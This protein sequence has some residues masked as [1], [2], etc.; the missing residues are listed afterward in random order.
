[1]KIIEKDIESV[2]SSFDPDILS[3][4]T[5]FIT[6]GT[7]LIGKTL[8]PVLTGL[9]AKVLLLVRSEEK[10]K[11]LF[12]ET[13]AYYVGTVETI[14]A[15]DRDVDYVIHMASPT[16]SQFFVNHPV[17]T[18]TTAIQGTKNILELARQK[19]VSGLVYLSSME[20]YGYP[21]K[22]HMITEDE[23]SGFDTR[24]PRNSYP[25]SKL[26]CEMMCSAYASEYGVPAKVARLTQT[27]GPGVEY[28]DG[29]IFAEMMRCVIEKR[30]IV[31]HTTGETERCYLYTADA[32]SAV[33][34][35]LLKGESREVYNVANECTYCSIREMA[36]LV[37]KLGSI[38][39]QYEI[40]TVQRGY[41]G[42]LYS[43]L[44]TKKIRNL[45]WKPK[46]GI[47]EIFERMIFSQRENA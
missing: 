17:E 6:G 35:V 4:K 28:N 8:V 29:R 23:V 22:G 33:L 11:G 27:F 26:T 24:I 40:D 39:V 37:A 19:N 25:L 7:G 13:C 36:E 30:D 21:K 18:M 47:R 15:I 5:V 12:G 1:V 14:P 2:V 42:T 46:V 34:T 41:A 16:S 10:A 38:K 44:D 43:K 3:G 31:L 32:A 20:I 45:G 9:G